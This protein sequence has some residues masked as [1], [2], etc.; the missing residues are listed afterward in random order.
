MHF[1]KI[2]YIYRMHHACNLI[3]CNAIECH[4]MELQETECS[5]AERKEMEPT[6][7]Y[8]FV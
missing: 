4:G 1:V 8:M 7:A 5:G 3:G 2:L 6:Y